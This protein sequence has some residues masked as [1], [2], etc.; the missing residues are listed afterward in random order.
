MEYYIQDYEL[1]LLIIIPEEKMFTAR[2]RHLCPSA[3]IIIRNL[4]NRKRLDS[5]GPNPGLDKRIAAFK[6][7]G[8]KVDDEDAE[9]YVEQ[10]ESD[11]YKVRIYLLVANML[12]ISAIHFK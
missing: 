6:R 5:F 2:L 7:D 3:K 4:R 9:E 1:Q 11:F 8:F 10:S 12:C